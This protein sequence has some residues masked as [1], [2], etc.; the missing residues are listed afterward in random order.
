MK[1]ASG[2][3]ANLCSKTRERDKA[4]PSLS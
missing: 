4:L 2:V 1:V 3:H